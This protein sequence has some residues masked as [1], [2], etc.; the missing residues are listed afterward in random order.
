MKKVLTVLA[1]LAIVA[2]ASA[3][4]R[5][6]VT[7]SGD[8]YGLETPANHMIPTISTVY[9]NGDNVNGYDYSDYYQTTPGPIR[10]GTFPPDAAPSGTQANPIE[11]PLGQWAYIW[12]QFQSESKGA[13]INGLQVAVV[14]PG[15][16][17]DPNLPTPWPTSLTNTY[18]LCNN[19]QVL[20]GTPAIA[21]KR[22]DG[23]ATPPAYPEWH[24]NQQ[25][26]VAINAY[27]IQNSPSDLAW[28]LY[29][30]GT[31]RMA[32]LG[33]I[34]AVTIDPSKVFEIRIVNFS[35][36]SGAPGGFSAG[37]FKFTPEPASLM[38]LGLAG[39][40]IRRR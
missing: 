9:A 7:K 12:L 32:L 29:K 22:W 27:G 10:P 6:F 15:S 24:N 5:V 40:L 39:L 14:D 13:K 31:A 30:G 25:V 18:Y 34:E 17:W 37:F 21:N 1:V 20:G 8:G 4:V 33:A 19:M 36:S 38:L 26:G 2:T 11:I 28:N 23:V 16:V 3:T 35:Y